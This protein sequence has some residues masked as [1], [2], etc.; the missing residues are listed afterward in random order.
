MNGDVSITRWI[1]PTILATAIIL[2]G[3]SDSTVSPKPPPAPATLRISTPVPSA[4]IAGAA[5]TPLPAVIVGDSN[6]NPIAGVTVV[7]SV[8][9]GAGSATG[10]TQ[11]TNSAGVASPGGWTL[12][13][14]VGVNAMTASVAALPA[15]TFSVL[16]TSGAATR[17]TLVSGAGQSD[18]TRSVLPLQLIVRATDSND[19]PVAGVPIA[20]A[21]T[22][23]S[24]VLSPASAT[25]STGQSS[26]TL[27]LGDSAGTYVVQATSGT[28][29]GSPVTFSAVAAWPLYRVASISMGLTHTCAIT[30]SQQLNCWGDN[31]DGELGD[32]TTTQR[33]SPTVAA[34]GLHFT[35]VS[36]LGVFSCGIASGAAYCWGDNSQSGIGDGTTTDRYIPTPVAGGLSFT[37]IGAGG[38]HSCAL[39]AG[40]DAYCWG[41]SQLGA[42]GDGTNA[43]TRPSPVAVTGGLKFTALAIGSQH[44]CGLATGG[45][46]Y[47]WGRNPNGEVGDGTTTDRNAPTAVTGGLVFAS[48]TAGAGDTCGVTASGD[49]YC[50][51]DNRVGQLGVGNT[52]DQAAPTKVG[53]GYA[54][55]QLAASSQLV[56]GITTNGSLYCWGEDTV[57]GGGPASNLPVTAP[58]P[59]VAP[60]G[61]TFS[62]VT[63]GDTGGCAVSTSSIAYCWGVNVRGEVGDGTTMYRQSLVAVI[64]K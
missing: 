23:G 20:F 1:S 57:T 10:L 6:G 50:W 59:V 27:T 53:G 45:V 62:S 11:V 7:F 63:T 42:V 22:Q 47:C 54:F 31:Q 32:G 12:G 61:V 51:G 60:A 48:L 19:N 43:N 24:G 13:P 2:S 46:A 44:S 30:P 55:V 35:R 33:L 15:I 3:C 8:T 25:D 41:I 37:E 52:T 28:L 5:V 38:D 29:T 4:S 17:L 18:T 64:P 56:C 39:T 58:R 16:G 14:R 36:T 26:V 9:A 34:G 21:F 40:G 49:A